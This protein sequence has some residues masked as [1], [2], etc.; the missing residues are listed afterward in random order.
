MSPYG[1][2]ELSPYRDLGIASG[3]H[4]ADFLLS[5]AAPTFRHGRS[6]RHQPL[7]VVDEVGKNGIDVMSIDVERRGCGPPFP[8]IK[9]VEPQSF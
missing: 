1:Q 3:K 4:L 7:A 8:R 2:N 6:A 9:T 5:D